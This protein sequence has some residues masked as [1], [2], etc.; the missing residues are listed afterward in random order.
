LLLSNPFFAL[1]MGIQKI[2]L[3]HV[4]GTGSLLFELAGILGLVPFGITLS[5]VVLVYAFGAILSALLCFV[6][7]RR[8][9][10][11]LRLRLESVSRRSIIDLVHYTARWS[12]TVSTSLLAPVIDKLILARFVGLSSV[13]IYEAASKL[14]EILKR[15]TQLLLLPVFPMAGAVVPNQSEEQTQALYRRI[16]SANLAIDAGLYLIPATL[17]FGIM[18]VWLGLELSGI[19][20]WAF[21]VLSITGFMLAL[22]TPAALI[23]AGT[24]RMRLL[25]TTGLTALSLNVFLSS[26]LAKRFGFWGLLGGTAF[27]YG[28]QSVVILASLQRRKEFALHLGSFFHMGLVAVGS[29]VA[30]PLILVEVFGREV[31]AVKLVAIGIF[32]IG[33]YLL[34]LLTFEENRRLAVSMALHIRKVITAR[35]VGRRAGEMSQA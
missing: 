14:V 27:A 29:A 16:F 34:A 32:S 3:S 8:H 21:L 9:L 35:L 11:H 6:L 18:R 17:T 2:H 19:A 25:V 10:P 7:V 30:P 15:A 31:G 26:L 12:V 24:G 23:L 4:V 22:V 33:I 5:R 13:A 28:G 1:L 20:G